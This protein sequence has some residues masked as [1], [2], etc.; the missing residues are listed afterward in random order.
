[1]SRTVLITGA[2]KRVG[3][4]IALFLAKSGRYNLALHYHNSQEYADLLLE[5]VKSYG[6]KAQIYKAD[7][8]VKDQATNLIEEVQSDFGDLSVLI[9]SAS[10]FERKDFLEVEEIDL[11]E[12]MQ[13]NLY[14]PFFLTQAFAKLGLEGD[15]INIT[16]TMVNGNLPVFFPYLLSK[17][18]F[19]SFSEMSA[20][21]LAP[22]IKVNEICPGSVLYDKHV[23]DEPLIGVNEKLPGKI[24]PSLKDLC[25]TI[26][27]I[28]NSGSYYGQRFFL[29]A[30]ERLL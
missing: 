15:I 16:D 30:G 13:I 9:N 23:S 7:L 1:M 4:E 21:R 19:S 29:D 27:F 12:N 2:A 8:R 22:K 25:Q 3:K 20:L 24:Y 10:I 5:E 6:V 28:L 17:K 14:A 11:Y 26:E 18:A